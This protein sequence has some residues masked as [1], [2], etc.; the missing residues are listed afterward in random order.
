MSISNLAVIHPSAQIGD[1]V[2]IEPFAIID[3][4]VI[5]G[6]HTWI[7]AQVNI[8]KGTRLGKACRIHQGAIVG[9][10]TQDLKYAR[11]KTTLEIGDE[12]TIREYCTINKSTTAN[13]S[14]QIKK[15]ALIMAYAHIA[16]DCL[17][18]QYAIISNNV[19]LAGHVYVGA[20]AIV[21]GMTAVQQFILIGDHAFIGGGTLVRKDVPP[22]IRV[23]REPLS[24]VGVNKIGLRR[25]GYSPSDIKHISDI[26]RILMV[27]H[28]NLSKG[29]KTLHTEISDSAYKEEIIEFILKS[30]RGIIRG[31]RRISNDEY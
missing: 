12:V 28:Q 30:Q 9:G 15:G 11:E 19:Q 2:T 7:G 18:D 6:D 23:A 17:I 16:H 8:R 27:K 22:Y 5:I 21:G 20:H 31:F 26:Y 14:T 1:N 4:D 13:G 25:R 3:Q 24:Y 29:M 10:I